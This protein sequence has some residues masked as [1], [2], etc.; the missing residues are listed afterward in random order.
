MTSALAEFKKFD[1]KEKAEAWVKDNQ[2]FT[3]RNVEGKSTV[4]QLQ[5]FLSSAKG[6]KGWTVVGPNPKALAVNIMHQWKA[7]FA[8]KDD[9][10]TSVEISQYSC[11]QQN[12]HRENERWQ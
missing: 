3:V 2:F 11:Q 9:D 10:T 5:E 1:S 6:Q 12:M 7:A 8:K 4:M